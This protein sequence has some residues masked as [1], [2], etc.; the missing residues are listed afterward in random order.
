MKSICAYIHHTDA[1]IILYMRP[2]NE[3]RC[4]IVSHWLGVYTKWSLQMRSDEKQCLS[5]IGLYAHDGIV[6]G[7][8]NPQPPPLKRAVPQSFFANPKQLLNWRSNYLWFMWRPYNGNKQ[9]LTCVNICSKWKIICCLTAPS[10]CQNQCW[11]LTS[12]SLWLSA[13]VYGF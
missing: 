9:F 2:P 13:R 3:R 11:L 5:R 8:H 1:G 4:Y 10:H 12:E 6:R 7:L